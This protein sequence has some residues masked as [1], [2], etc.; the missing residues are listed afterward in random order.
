MASAQTTS[1]TTRLSEQH[2]GRST[3]EILVRAWLLIFSVVRN[4]SSAYTPG[5][6][7]SFA[8]SAPLDSLFAEKF[9][10]IVACRREFA[11][12]WAGAEQHSFA[13]G[14]PK[15][16]IDK[17]A[18]AKADKDDKFAAASYKL[19]ADPQASPAT[20][21]NFP[22]TAFAYLLRRFVMC[23]KFCLICFKS[24]EFSSLKAFVCSSDLCLFQ[25]FNLD[26]AVSLEV[27]GPIRIPFSLAT[28]NRALMSDY[29]SGTRM[30]S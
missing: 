2:L 22:L 13:L 16:A 4:H 28:P 14:G 19:P 25:L 30:S 12:G 15:S 5:E 23:S 1:L 9:E 26:L 7:E 17:K 3:L 6:F 21:D 27:S 11:V 29:R 10:Q 20:R 18:A 8:L 24:T